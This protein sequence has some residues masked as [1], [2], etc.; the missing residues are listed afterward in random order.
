MKKLFP[1]LFL[2]LATTAC[3]ETVIST[4][5]INI[6]VKLVVGCFISPQDDTLYATVTLSKPLYKRNGNQFDFETV[7]NATVQISDGSTSATF[8]YNSDLGRYLLPRATFNIQSGRTYQLEVSTPDGKRIKASTTVPAPQNFNFTLQ[9][10]N[11]STSPDDS[12]YLMD[13]RWQGVP[14][15]ERNY[16]FIYGIRT[17]SSFDDYEYWPTA[18]EWNASQYF[19]DLTQENR[20]YRFRETIYAGWRNPFDSTQISLTAVLQELDIHSYRYFTSLAAQLTTGG[21]FSEPVVIYSNVEDGLGCFGSHYQYKIQ[22][23]SL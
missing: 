18:D 16:R 11:T 19:S 13:A 20:N 21:G 7:T 2:L 22:R 12:R 14:G 15:P 3:R 5:N 4:A 10:T 8:T 9:L 1:I 17:V 6:P 23:D